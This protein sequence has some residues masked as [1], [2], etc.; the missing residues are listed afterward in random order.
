MTTLKLTSPYMHG[1]L[2]VRVQK[3]LAKKANLYSRIDGIYGPKTEYSVR[4]FQTT[5]GCVV[6]GTVDPQTW[7]VLNGRKYVAPKPS[8]HNVTPAEV[9]VF[10]L[11]HKNRVNYSEKMGLRMWGIVHRVKWWLIG[12]LTIWFDCSG[13]CT[14]CYWAA[15]R[16]DPNGPSF[17]YNGYGYSQTLWA[18]GKPVTYA[19]ANDLAF[20]GSNGQTEHVV[21]CLN[22]THAV[23]MG[24]EGGPY[25]VAFREYR[26]DFMGVRRYG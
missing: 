11:N 17:N 25:L 6:N 12:R 26:S 9:A 22:N 16:K 8:K 20:Y 10:I 7:A 24:M 4:Q 19:A 1:P 23:S 2:V 18:N 21:M 15:H 5:H 14:F 13:F 3:L